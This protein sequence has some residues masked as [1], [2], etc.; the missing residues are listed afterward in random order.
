MSGNPS[1][2]S[3]AIGNRRPSA[4]FLQHPTGLLAMLGAM[5]GAMSALVPGFAIEGM[6]SSLGL[7]MVMAGVWFGLV[8]AIG[9]WRFVG[10]GPAAA[11][12]VLV[13]TWIA[14][15]VAVNLAMQISEY[16]LKISALPDTP[17]YYLAGFAAGAVGASLTWAGAAWFCPALRPGIV[18]ACIATAGALLGLL[19]PWSMSGDYPAILFVPWQAGVA[20]TLGHFV[21]SSASARNLS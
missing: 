1:S 5:S 9:V 6:P 14:W 11:V 21:G 12:A 2:A 8:V 20:A 4:R 10:V 18:A 19:L 7:F 3:D 16:S 17:R 15:E 13:S